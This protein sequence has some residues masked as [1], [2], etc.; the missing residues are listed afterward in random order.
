MYAFQIHTQSSI[1][2]LCC[3]GYSILVIFAFPDR[4]GTWLTNSNLVFSILSGSIRMRTH[5]LHKR[6]FPVRSIRW[7][8]GTI[9]LTVRLW[10]NKRAI[11]GYLFGTNLSFLLGNYNCLWRRFQLW[12]P[13]S[14]NKKSRDLVGAVLLGLR[15]C[16]RSLQFHQI[17]HQS[18]L[19]L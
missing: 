13:T 4:R 18:L 8:F 19:V 14:P 10:C 17:D 16:T 2:I 9:N 11:N 7:Y 3:R 5:R 12:L 6:L 1:V 15:N